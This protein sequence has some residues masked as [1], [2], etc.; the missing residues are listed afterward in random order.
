MSNS[1]TVMSKSRLIMT[2][3]TLVIA[4]TKHQRKHLREGGIYVDWWYEDAI[5]HDG[6]GIARGAWG[7]ISC[8]VLNRTAHS[9]KSSCPVHC[10]LYIHPSTSDH[11]MV[12]SIVRLTFRN[13]F[14]SSIDPLWTDLHR[15]S[16]R[17]ISKVMLNSIKFTMKVHHHRLNFC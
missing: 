17:Y 8:H 16:L 1:F 5:L 9:E 14:L 13:Y 11:R 15:H 6:E 4:V 10:L 2:R 12:L 3:N 7:S